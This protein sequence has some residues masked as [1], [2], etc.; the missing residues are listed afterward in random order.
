VCLWCFSSMIFDSIFN[1]LSKG[2]SAKKA[3]T[4]RLSKKDASNELVKYGE[5]MANAKRYDE[6]LTL[7]EKALSINPNND[8]AWGDKALILDKVGNTAD[9][10]SSFS[11]AI[12]INP[13]NSVT[14]LNKGL[15]LLRMR[16]FNESIEC[17]DTALKLNNSYA[18]AWYNKGRALAMLG[19]N[20]KSQ[21]CLD[22]ARKLDPML[23]AKLTRVK[24]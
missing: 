6:A 15:T 18:K 17:F 2:H 23:Y 19:E 13:N 20:D 14:W 1:R 4:L 10:L 8:M 7:F 22:K 16:K 24:F 12:S 5:D 9:A 11:K 21:P 3:N